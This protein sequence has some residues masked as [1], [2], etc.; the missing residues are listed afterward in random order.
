MNDLDTEELGSP[1]SGS[2]PKLSS[3][4]ASAEKAPKKQSTLFDL[5]V[6]GDDKEDGQQKKKKK[7]KE[8]EDATGDGDGEDDEKGKKS[9]KKSHHHHDGDN[10]GDDDKSKK[11][12]KK[13]KKMEVDGE[14]DEKKKP[15]KSA[16]KRGREE[17]DDGAGGDG[18][19]DEPPLKKKKNG[20]VL[21]GTAL[22]TA[23]SK[24]TKYQ[25]RAQLR[26]LGIKVS[27]FLI[28]YACVRVRACRCSP[29][30]LAVRCRER[31]R[32]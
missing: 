24:L 32:N 25:L 19:S 30:F 16:K 3:A 23:L 9:K 10:D 22:S 4:L 8:D 5:G 13:S 17:D 11:A 15:G 2:K 28:M 31:S 21:S 18:K 20:P 29:V 14:E 12:Q 26:D 6:K 27:F 1:T 7:R